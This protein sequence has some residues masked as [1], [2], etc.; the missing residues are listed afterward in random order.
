MNKDYPVNILQAILI[1]LVTAAS[2]VA[3]A[4]APARKFDVASIKPAAPGARG[5]FI[6][7]IAGGVAVTNMT[8]KEL[9]II[10]YRI[11]PF[12]LSGGPDWIDSARYDISAKS[13][14]A[15]KT[16]EIPLMLQGLL[17]DRFQLK[18]SRDTKDLP[19]FAL[20]VA[21]KDG[22]PGPKLVEAKEGACSQP[23]PSKPPTPPTPGQPPVLPCGGMAMGRESLRG[24]GMAVSQLA[25]MLSRKLGRS[26]VD[27]TGLTGKYDIS[28]EWTS[29]DAQGSPS[30]P[31]PAASPSDVDAPFFTALQEQLGLKL[32][33]QKGPVPVVVVDHAEKPSEN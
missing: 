18:I 15:P 16:T 19:I 24:A 28:M 3:Q 21:R 31:D 23:D 13:D 11:Q 29:D 20:V 14:N 25:P 7:P 30:Q 33:S 32:E 27:K 22:K 8:L 4:E 2:V 6:R 26:V 12:Q 1:S 9:I 17:A 5:M 10:A